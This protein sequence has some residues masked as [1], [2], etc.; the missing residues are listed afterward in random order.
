MARVV[1][2]D[3]HALVRSGIR[4][5]LEASG[6][7]VVGEAA[8]GRDAVRLVGEQTPDVALLDVAMPLQSG[9]EAAREIRRLHPA[10]KIV[11]LSMHDEPPYIEQAEA[12]GATGYVLKE[13]AF[14]QLLQVIEAVMTGVNQLRAPG[15]KLAGG[16]RKSGSA[17]DLDRLTSREQQVLALIAE[18]KSSIEIGKVLS[19]SPRTVDTH[20]KNIMDKLAVHSIAGLTRFAIRHGLCLLEAERTPE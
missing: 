4:S 12:A 7:E 17:G 15:G 6:I 19:I 16:P 9:I 3:D 8:N 5:L 20:R 10:V 18:G 1:L 14:E 13:S 2:A 11:M